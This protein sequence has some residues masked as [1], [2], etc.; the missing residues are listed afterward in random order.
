MVGQGKPPEKMAQW[1]PQHWSLFHQFVKLYRHLEP[2]NLVACPWWF[3]PLIH[4]PG[5]QHL[6]PCLQSSVV[7]H[8]KGKTAVEPPGSHE[9]N[10]FQPAFPSPQPVLSEYSSPETIAYPH[11]FKSTFFTH[12]FQ[13]ECSVYII[14]FIACSERNKSSEE[15]PVRFVSA[16]TLNNN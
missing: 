10:C 11:I 7:T 12:L 16:D 6:C 3:P 1:G 13:L 15:L 5:V 4:T 2:N 8:R 14:M 9:R